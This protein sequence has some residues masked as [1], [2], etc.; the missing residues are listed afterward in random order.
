MVCGLP[1]FHTGDMSEDARPTAFVSEADGIF[2]AELISALVARGHQVFALT[3][4]VESARI[5]RG[6]GAVAVIGDLLTPGRWQDEAAADWVFHLPSPQPAHPI[7]TRRTRERTALAARARVL[8]DRN[9]FEAVSAGTTRRIVYVAD[10]RLYGAVGTRPITEDEPPRPSAF[11][12][13]LL[14]AL[15]RVEG[16]ALAG[17]PIVTAFPGVVYGK[18]GWLRELVMEPIVAGRRVLQFGTTG[19]LVSPIHIHDCVRALLHLAEHGERAS[20]YFL[21]NSEPIRFNAFATTFARVAERPL[22]VWRLPAPTARL[23]SRRNIGGYIQS[24]AAFSN[25][26]LRGNGFRFEYPTLEQGLRQIWESRD[27]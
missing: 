12:A 15:D 27:E 13:S 19:P 3:R 1:V 21:V 22:R 9:L 25:I 17:V 11:G 20:R 26:R 18:D 6:S 4:S 5:V 14:P 23:V 10:I 16:Y 8:M 2:G 24:D 7:W